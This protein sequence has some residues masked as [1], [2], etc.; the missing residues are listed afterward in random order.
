VVPVH[1][2]REV[3]AVARPPREVLVAVVVHLLREVTAAA[4]FLSQHLPRY[5]HRSPPLPPLKETAVALL[6][7]VLEVVARPPRVA[8][9]LLLRA[10]ADPLSKEKI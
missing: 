1:L 3:L 6:Q 10:V 4:A 7:R 2:Q 8:E 9:K 5:Q